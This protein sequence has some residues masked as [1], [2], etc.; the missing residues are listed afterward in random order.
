MHKTD[1]E[2]LQY[3]WP[4][5]HFLITCSTVEGDANIIAVSFCMPV[6]KSPPM[7]AC[8]IGLGAYSCE[9]IGQTREFVV[10]VPPQDLKRQVSYCGFHSGRQVKKFEEAGLTPEPAR[11]VRVPIIK[12]CVAHMECRVEQMIDTGDKRL[13]VRDHPRKPKLR[14]R[15]RFLGRLQHSYQ[16]VV[17]SLFAGNL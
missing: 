4:M 17:L 1:V 14:L 11:S 3:M 10:N 5:R 16:N 2:Y 9:I 7:L 15:N 12:E 13:F 6:S 8:A